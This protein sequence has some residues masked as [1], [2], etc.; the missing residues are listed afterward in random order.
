MTKAERVFK[1]NFPKKNFDKEDYD[2]MKSWFLE[3][4]QMCIETIC[5]DAY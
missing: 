3:G 2:L 4:W 1:K 5:E